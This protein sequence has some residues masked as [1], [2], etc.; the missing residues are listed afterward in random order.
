MRFATVV[1]MTFSVMALPARGAEIV[2][3]LP[4][5]QGG[6]DSSPFNIYGNDFDSK[7]GTLQSAS[8]EL[9]GIY[10][11]RIYTPNGAGFTNPVPADVHY[12]FDAF[13]P[14]NSFSGN[15][16]P[17][18]LTITG[19]IL[20][21]RQFNVD[22]KFELPYLNNFEANTSRHDLLA[23]FGIFSFVT[24]GGLGASSDGSTFNGSLVLTYTYAVPEPA[25]AMMFGT[26]LLI[27]I[28]AYRGR[29]RIR[30]E[31]SGSLA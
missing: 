14:G 15:L 18:P 5:I 11:A 20:S 19:N 3:L 2:Q 29:L 10:Q 23:D 28:V 26:A 1:F 12:G 6:I 9:L 7:L 31:I 13:G 30:N 17:L 22:I 8:A 24:G 27:A 16:G 25:S 21:S 4:A